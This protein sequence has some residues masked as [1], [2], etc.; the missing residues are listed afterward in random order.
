MGVE[1]KKKKNSNKNTNNNTHVLE[2]E[3][4]LEVEDPVRGTQRM[5]SS[6]FLP[7]GRREN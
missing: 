2:L 5:G 7:P 4:E 6:A 1:F 3:E